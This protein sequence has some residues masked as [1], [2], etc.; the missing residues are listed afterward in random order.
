MMTFH[1]IWC[2][3]KRILNRFLPNLTLYEILDFIVQI[4]N[5]ASVIHPII[6]FFDNLKIFFVDEH[7]NGGSWLPCPLPK[8]CKIV[9]SFQ[10]E[11]LEA[12]KAREE[13][14][15]LRVLTDSGQNILHL[16]KLGAESADNVLHQWLDMKNRK[17]TNYQFRVLQNVFSACSIP[18]FCKLAFMESI[19][20]RSYFEKEQTCLK[21]SIESS[22]ESLFEKVECKFG[23]SIVRHAF[24][25]ITASKSGIS[26]NELEDV[27][28][29]DDKVL[30]SIYEDQI[31]SVR[32]VPAIL[33]MKIKK[34]VASFLENIEA[35]GSHVFR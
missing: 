18:L 4:L 25:Y 20:W 10:Q 13:Q 31:P 16:E 3:S 35:D 19:K 5:L 32:R 17:L 11:E 21:S 24:A 22:I 14:E 29:L 30:N 26:D 9:I 12:S 33:V 27:L 15:F 7:K 2:H 23:R 34:E 28:S 8:Y 1:M 6:I